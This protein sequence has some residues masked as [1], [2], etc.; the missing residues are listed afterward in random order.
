[1]KPSR[2]D[3]VALVRDAA[4]MMLEL[5]AAGVVVDGCRQSP[6]YFAAREALKLR[7]LEDFP[8]PKMEDLED[9]AFMLWSLL[10]D[11]PP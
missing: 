7:G 9:A 11:V 4:F 2:D 8:A 10:K 1:M 6:A 5:P 3:I